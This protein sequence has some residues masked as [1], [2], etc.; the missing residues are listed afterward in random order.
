MAISDPVADMLTKVRNA[1]LA[2]HEKVDVQT[3]NIKLQIIKI[4]KNEGNI[5][6]CKKLLKNS[7]NSARRVVK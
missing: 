6:N 7:K 4:L 3:S 5:K 2:K 1:N